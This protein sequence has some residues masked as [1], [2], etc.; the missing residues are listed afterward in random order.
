MNI[1][2]D[3]VVKI[4]KLEIADEFLDQAIECYLDK[5]KYV[6]ALHL[7][8]AAQEIY[9]KWLRCNKGQ[10]FS[11]IMM[12]HAETLAK[13]HSLTFDRKA[14]KKADKHAKNTIKHFDNKADRFAELDPQLDSVIML[15]EAVTEHI[16]LK[17]IETK[18]IERFKTYFSKTRENGL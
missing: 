17:R 7:A 16:M 13:E 4:D 8:G 9:G 18:N 15:S 11:S 14:H 3:V 12:N 2:G 1:I 6:T 5:S 10:D